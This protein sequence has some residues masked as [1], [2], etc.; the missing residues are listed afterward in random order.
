MDMDYA[1]FMLTE[2]RKGK[3]NPAVNSPSKRGLY[4]A[5]C[6]QHSGGCNPGSAFQSKPLILPFEILLICF[7]KACL[8]MGFF[9]NDFDEVKTLYYCKQFIMFQKPSLI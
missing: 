7:C 4:E 9:S 8:L 2:G 3:E 6:C 1:H 5:T